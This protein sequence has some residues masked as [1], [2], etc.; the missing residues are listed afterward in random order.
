MLKEHLLVDNS[1]AGSEAPSVKM[2]DES[3]SIEGSISG[4]GNDITRPVFGVPNIVSPEYSINQQHNELLSPVNEPPLPSD[5]P[6]KRAMAVG[7]S[8]DQMLMLKDS[9]NNNNNYKRRKSDNSNAQS[10]IH[11]IDKPKASLQSSILQRYLI[12]LIFGLLLN[13][14]C[15][16]CKSTGLIY[17]EYLDY[18]VDSTQVLEYGWDVSENSF[19]ENTWQISDLKFD[20]N[21]IENSEIYIFTIFLGFIILLINCFTIGV[22]LNQDMNTKDN[23]CVN[24]S[25][26]IEISHYGFHYY[27][28]T[29]MIIVDLFCIIHNIYTSQAIETYYTSHLF[30]TSHISLGWGFWFLLLKWLLITL[31]FIY[32]ITDLNCIRRSFDVPVIKKYVYNYDSIMDNSRQT[33]SYFNNEM[34]DKLYL[35]IIFC[36]I[37]LM[38]RYSGILTYYFTYDYISDSGFAYHFNNIG[39]VG[40]STDLDL[41]SIDTVNNET[42]MGVNALWLTTVI[43]N[44]VWSFVLVFILMHERD[45]AEFNLELCTCCGSCDQCSITSDQDV[46]YVRRSIGVITLIIGLLDLI[47][48]ILKVTQDTD[49]ITN[50]AVHAIKT[51]EEFVDRIIFEE[52]DVYVFYGWF[53]MLFILILW[54]WIAKSHFSKMFDEHYIDHAIGER[55]NQSS[56]QSRWKN[57]NNNNNHSDKS[58]NDDSSNISYLERLKKSLSIGGLRSGSSRSQNSNSIQSNNNSNSDEKQDDDAYR[59]SILWPSGRKNKFQPPDPIIENKESD[60]SNELNSKKNNGRNKNSPSP[61]RIRSPKKS[62]AARVRAISKRF[63][64]NKHGEG[65]TQTPVLLEKDDDQSQSYEDMYQSDPMTPDGANKNATTQLQ[66]MAGHGQVV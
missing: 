32:F 5:S 56:S 33:D 65:V 28:M 53:L 13:F 58:N 17:I 40:Y 22:I 49:Y 31:A 59:R 10:R 11:S 50:N 38:C 7:G 9:S 41:Y 55:I 6:E 16:F 18:V 2:F 62:M 54:V 43:L 29:L 20:S 66:Q 52:I 26:H 15:I 27:C 21:I 39:N 45:I 46:T 51:E 47:C 35:V 60:V 36:C 30:H 24:I 61:R 42:I 19:D 63:Q 1:D 37:L 48:L 3:K 57:N 8:Q 25:K 44:L 34:F 4:T 23:L 14:I 64:A 12:C